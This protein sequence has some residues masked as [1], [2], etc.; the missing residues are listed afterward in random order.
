MKTAAYP[1]APRRPLAACT[2]FLILGL[3]AG[4][5]LSVQTLPLIIG[6]AVCV[7]LGAVMKKQGKSLV[8][9]LSLLIFFLSALVSASIM[10][11]PFLPPGLFRVSGIVE[12]E[13]A[14]RENGSVRVTLR[15]AEAV[16]G[17]GVRTHFGKAYWTFYPREDE[18]LIQLSD[19]LYDGDRITF[20]ASAYTPQG[21]VNPYG[22][23]FRLYLLQG[24]FR[25]AISGCSDP[26]LEKE[27]SVSL[28]GHIFRLRSILLSRMDEIFGADAPWPE[29]LLLGVRDR[30]EED[31]VEAFRNLGIAHILAVSGLHVGM[32]A[33]FVQWLLRRL[34]VGV[35][36]QSAVLFL[37]LL[38]YSALLQFTASV[39]RAS[40]LI[41][42]A[43]LRRIVRRPPDPL[44]TLSLAA[45][46]I[47]LVSPLQVMAAG[48]QLTFAA[49]LGIIMLRE[50]IGKALRFI[51]FRAVREA[52]SVT[53][54]AS[55]AVLIP[56]AGLFHSVSLS[57]LVLS[58]LAC[59]VMA[60]LLPAF[61]LLTVLGIVCLPLGQALAAFLHVLAA[62]MIPVSRAISETPYSHISV[63]AFPFVSACAL[64]GILFLTTR[65]C[66]LPR[67]KR[68]ALACAFSLAGVLIPLAQR[69]GRV[70]Y[71]QF[72]QG[73]SDAALIEDGPATVVIDAGENGSD[74][75][76]YL[77]S[78]G[79]RADIVLLTH[80]HTDHCA[81]VLDLIADRVE[82]GKI[83]IAP[84][85]EAQR[86]DEGA[87]KVLEKAR[88]TGIPV[89]T[90]AAG[91]SFSTGRARF[92]ILWPVR[93]H[94]RTGQD[95]NDYSMTVLCEAQGV[96]ILFTGDL[97]AK[98]EPYAAADADILK[99]A[100][101]GSAD[102]TEEAFLA[103]TTPRLSIIT[104][105]SGQYLPSGATLDRLKK[106]GSAV[107]RTDETGA[108]RVR[109]Q[110]G[111]FEITPFL[112]PSP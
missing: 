34:G 105:R 82:I 40:V 71:I 1:F 18:T 56:G 70:S 80:L 15:D 36:G 91:D 92:D 37:L 55:L 73:Q 5:V 60:A 8:Y 103:G 81:G 22:F 13:A 66:A 61:I 38:F 54:A 77:L 96:R 78:V 19:S 95:P 75:A 110:N 72:S 64:I 43:S 20:T 41:L 28:S 58:P 100:H 9:A 31:T 51:P 98:Y 48:F 89:E 23:N 26:V 17:E 4:I 90:L 63:T 52:L 35:K 42:L 94:I 87:A 88:E 102:S 84:L 46:L 3:A 7:L 6:A 112:S 25:A 57:G 97:T 79:R 39:V 104:C 33:V 45:L 108:I 12:G 62:W 14:K 65:Y 99:V 2:L 27:V 69:D 111:E 101:H 44:S 10:R 85:A 83:I 21:Q 74:L 50:P 109:L 32:I 11:T 24:G 29:A 67:N 107:L 47:L 53:A 59:L 76:A 30:L 49:V 106:S 68:L 93:E 16:N 86:I